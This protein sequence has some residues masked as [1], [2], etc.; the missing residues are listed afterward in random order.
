VQET[1]KL[2][3]PAS[4]G[5]DVFGFDD[6]IRLEAEGCYTK[7]IFIDGKSRIVS[8]TLKDFEDTLPN[9]KFFRIHKSH[10]INLKYI[11]DISNF[12]GNIVTMTDG[13]KLEISRRRA[14]SFIRKIKMVLKAI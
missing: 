4:H 10:L 9:D 2:V 6:I 11:K 3:L 13:S 8:R 14:P 7:V 5:F 12:D 1:D